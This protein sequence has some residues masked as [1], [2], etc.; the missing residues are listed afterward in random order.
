MQAYRKDTDNEAATTRTQDKSDAKQTFIDP[1]SVRPLYLIQIKGDQ[2]LGMA[3]GFVV[4][5]GDTYYLIT[6]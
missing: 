1:L 5:K 2:P 4:Q 3:T 6:N